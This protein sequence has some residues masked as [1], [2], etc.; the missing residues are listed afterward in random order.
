MYRKI[1]WLRGIRLFLVSFEHGGIYLL[2]GYTVLTPNVQTGVYLVDCKTGK[3][4]ANH[5]LEQFTITYDMYYLWKPYYG[6]L[7]NTKNSAVDP[8]FSCS[9]SISSIICSALKYRSWRSL[10]IILFTI[11]SIS[12]GFRVLNSLR[13]LGFLW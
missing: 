4:L 1:R 9:L 13:E 10:A 7:I 5:S 12:I 8:Y 11:F 2:V 3:Y 6:Y